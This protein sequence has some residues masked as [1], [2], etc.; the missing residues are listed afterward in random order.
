MHAPQTQAHPEALAQ[1]HCDRCDQ[2]FLLDQPTRYA[3]HRVAWVHVLCPAATE[4]AIS[5]DRTAEVVTWSAVTLPSPTPPTHLMGSVEFRILRAW[6]EAEEAHPGDKRAS[7]AAVVTVIERYRAGR[8]L[9]LS[10]MWT[11]LPDWLRPHLAKPAAE[12]LPALLGDWSKSGEFMPAEDVPER[13][14]LSE[15]EARIYRWEIVNG[16]ELT[17]MQRELTP[18]PFRGDRQRWVAAEPIIAVRESAHS[19]VRGMFG[20]G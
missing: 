17:D 1:V 14:R 6:I 13:W 16:Y 4:F 2:A 9:A 5:S 3:S 20:V 19:R 15:D 11:S 8:R 10:D 7:V 18:K 12:G